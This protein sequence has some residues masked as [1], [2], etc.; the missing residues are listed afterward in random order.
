MSDIYKVGTLRQGQIARGY[1]IVRHLFPSVSFDEW[2]LATGT[3]IQRRSWLAVTDPAGT[4]RGLCYIFVNHQRQ[5]RELEVP[6]FASVSLFDELGVA[7]ELF[8]VAKERARAFG[9]DKLHFWPAGPLGW[10]IVAEPEQASVP[11]EGLLYDL[12]TD[13]APEI[14]QQ[15]RDIPDAAH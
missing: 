13:Q 5:S 14:Q 11:S 7:R 10:S 6:I 8:D 12:N 2:K 1:A 9:Y 3:V 15:R 4:I